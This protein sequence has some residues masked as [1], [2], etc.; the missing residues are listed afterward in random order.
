[1]KMPSK[2]IMLPMCA[3]AL[4]AAGG[5][6]VAQVSAASDATSGQTS[7]VQKLAETF[8]LDK[9]KVQAVFDEQHKANAAKREAKYEDRLTQA[10]TDGKLTADQKSKILDEHAKLQTEMET[11]LKVDTATKADRKAAMDKVRTEAEDWAKANNIDAKW[12]MPGGRGMGG[13]G[14][15]GM[16]GHHGD[17][18]PEGDDDTATPDATPAS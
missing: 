15:G 1:M 9:S 10:V 13:H 17:M 14:P 5:F 3:L 2:K 16:G 11:A 12:L 4:V 7:I 18:G 6:G 8:H